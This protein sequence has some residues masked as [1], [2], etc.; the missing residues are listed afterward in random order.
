MKHIPIKNMTLLMITAVIWGTA[1]VAQQVG[2]NYVG[3]FAFSAIRCVLGGLVL[4]PVVILIN[5]F[6][7]T[8][9]RKQEG[10]RDTLIGGLICGLILCIASNLQQIGIQHTTV[11]KAGFI[12]ALYIVIVPILGIFLKKKAGL[13]LW[14]SVL[15]AIIGLYLLCMKD[16]FSLDL[17]DSL[18]FLC[19]VV[20]SVHILAIDYFSPKVDGVKMSCIQFIVAGVL[21]G[22]AMLLFESSP[23]IDMIYAARIPILYAGILS[24]GVAYTLQ[25]VGQKNVN[26]TIASLILSLEAVISVI[27]AWIILQQSMSSREI[28]GAVFMFASIILAQLPE[29]TSQ[30]NRNEELIQELE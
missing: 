17:G 9:Q 27:A 23:S 25:I 7:T 16:S 29:K 19:A 22:I 12:T 24:C 15:V 2:M 30:E 13:K 6:K 26:P 8:E 11:G 28:L 1:F 20:F 5:H 4:V 14:I 18:V 3:P 21:S 10:Q